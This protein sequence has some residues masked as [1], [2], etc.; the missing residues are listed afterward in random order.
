MT[1][2]TAKLKRHKTGSAVKPGAPVRAAA[3]RVLAEVLGGAAL[4]RAL[5]PALAGVAARDRG[6]CRELCAGTLR[7]APRLQGLLDQ[8][9]TRP[10]RRGDSDVQALALIGLYQLCATR[11]P[12]HGAVSASVDAAGAL[13]KARA[14]ALLNAVLRRYLREADTLLSRL[15]PAARAA[16]PAWLFDALRH[17][18]PRQ[19]A[20]I[21]Q[22]N[23]RRPPMT[24]RI[25]TARIDRQRYA[26]ELARAGIATRPGAL[27]PTALTLEA[28]RPVNELPGFES[29]RVSVQDE[30][31]QLAAVLLAPRR[32]E[33]ILDACAAPGGKTLHLLEAQPR[34]ALT[35]MDIH[36]ERLARVADNLERGGKR[37]ELMIGDGAAPPPALAKPFDAI[38]ADVPCSA[39]GVLRRHPD[40]KVLRR[41][42][43]IAGFARRQ[44]AILAG[45]WPLLRPGGRLLYVTCSIL[46]EE[47]DAVIAA[48]LKAH[49]DARRAAPSAAGAL[50]C[51]HGVQLLPDAQATDGLYFSLLHKGPSRTKGAEPEARQGLYCQG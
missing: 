9:L 29:G 36:G 26:A 47:N 20:Q 1:P 48:F 5:Q 6:L 43:D 4:E 21:V 41:R 23:N 8:L 40:I 3:A 22:A 39:S 37:A 13:G 25:D 27:V 18:W 34:I 38:L 31:A 10:L 24:L 14:G 42:E 46:R 45:L 28:A 2:A 51:A 11:I 16:H 35:A 44:A 49:A 32:G 19:Q 50:A 12:A 7:L 33:R 17:E 15:A 30:A